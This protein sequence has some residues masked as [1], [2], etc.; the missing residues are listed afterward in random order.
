MFSLVR[1]GFRCADQLPTE[2]DGLGSTPVRKEPKVADADEPSR[3]YMQQEPPQELM[4]GKSHLPL[5]VAMRVVLPPEGD[6]LSIEAQQAM[7]ADGDAMRVSGEI[8]EHVLRSAERR[9]CVHDPIFV[10]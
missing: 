10:R 5:L 8:V 1:C 3:K 6:L 4:C 9:F 2:G 7:I